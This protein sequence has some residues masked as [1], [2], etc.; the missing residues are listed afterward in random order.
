MSFALEI[1]IKAPVDVV[2]DYIIEDE[3]IKE[4][5]TF[6]I[7]NRYPLNM[8]QKSPCVGDK[9]ISV[10]KI[11]KKIFEAEVEILEYDAPHI[12]SLGSEMKQG[13]SA[14][15]YMLEEDEEDTVLTLI[16]E[17]EPSNFYYKFMYKLTGWISRGLTMEQIE[18][19]AECVETAYHKED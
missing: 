15:T 2:C 7:E 1:V 8:D 12:I 11:G 19:L 13:Y 14:M 6:I 5:N 18:R 10:Q 17:Y 9:Y 3:K 16:S 4:W